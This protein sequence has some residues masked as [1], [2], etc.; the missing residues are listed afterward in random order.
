MAE[1]EIV[2][3][4]TVLRQD[5]DAWNITIYFHGICNVEASTDPDAWNKILDMDSQLCVK[6]GQIALVC[7]P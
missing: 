1:S 7:G 4:T 2:V 6:N 3:P 5:L